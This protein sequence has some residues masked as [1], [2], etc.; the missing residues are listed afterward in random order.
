MIYD[1]NSAPHSGIQISGAK[2]LGE[3][4]YYILFREFTILFAFNLIKLEIMTGLASSRPVFGIW[5]VY[6]RFKNP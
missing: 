1:V 2:A 3:T 4:E 6:D 5:S